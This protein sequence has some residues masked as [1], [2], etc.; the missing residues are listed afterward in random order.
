MPE[1]WAERNL[2]KFNKN[3]CKVLHLRRST[4]VRAGG[5]TALKAPL[6][7]RIWG[8]P[9]DKFNMSQQSA[10]TAKKATCSILSCISKSIASTLEEIT[11]FLFSVLC[12]DCI[13]STVSIFGHWHIAISPV[14]ATKLARGLGAHGVWGE[15]EGTVV[16]QLSE[17][18]TIVRYCCLQ[19]PTGKV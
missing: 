2:M 1:E 13:W 7:K 12:E 15:A 8:L 3:K 6:Q 9:L 10:L 4:P 5:P 14:R 19:L 16:L 11:V 17:E 18:E